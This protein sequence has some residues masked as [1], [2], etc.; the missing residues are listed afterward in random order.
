MSTQPGQRGAILV[1]QRVNLGIG[2]VAIGCN[3]FYSFSRK[4]H[5]SDFKFCV[6][7]TRPLI[8]RQTAKDLSHKSL[9]IHLV[10]YVALWVHVGPTLSTRFFFV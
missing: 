2:T 1:D 6:V 5:K 8:D 9:V 3:S 7:S 10:S 4:S